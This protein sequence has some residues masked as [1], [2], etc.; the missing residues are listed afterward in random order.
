FQSVKWSLK[1]TQ[2]GKD[3]IG[4][5]STKTNSKGQTSVTVHFGPVAGSRTV[6]ASVAGFSSRTTAS[7][8]SAGPTT[9]KPTKKPKPTPTPTPK[10]PKQTAAPTR[11]PKA[12]TKPAQNPTPKPTKKPHHDATST[13]FDYPTDTPTFPLAS[14]SQAPVGVISPT[15]SETPLT[16]VI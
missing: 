7:C 8:S 16:G 10:P 5:S 6:N 2:S 14:A 9:P 12:T 4:P 3:K 15:P 13:P 11:T 1:T